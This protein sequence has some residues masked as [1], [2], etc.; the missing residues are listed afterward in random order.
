MKNLTQSEIESILPNVLEAPKDEGK[1]NM[2]VVRRKSG[3]RETRNEV[4]VSA[5][6]GV[7]GDRWFQSS[8]REKGAQI[9]W[10]NSRI[11]EAIAEG[12]EERMALAGDNFVVDMNLSAENLP[13]G[14]QL[15]M[16]EAIVEVSETPHTGCAKF[17][18]RFGSDALKFINH[19][20][21]RPLKL[22]GIYV[23]VVK[24]GL[25]RKGDLIRKI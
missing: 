13:I 11:L 20:D 8:K 9:T 2:I 21:R 5:E 24:P 25:V 22:R 18:K 10:M 15:S 14:Q 19:K 16:G 17:S 3:Q 6:L 7:E 1:I 12:D 23:F 4:Y